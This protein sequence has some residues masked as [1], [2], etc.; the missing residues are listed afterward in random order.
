MVKVTDML[1]QHVY[2]S[3]ITQSCD[4]LNVVSVPIMYLLIKDVLCAG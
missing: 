3:I 1:N 2:I 4:I